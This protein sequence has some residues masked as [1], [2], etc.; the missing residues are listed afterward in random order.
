[1]CL[2]LEF[3]TLD[4]FDGEPPSLDSITVPNVV[5]EWK[6]PEYESEIWIRYRISFQEGLKGGT[7]LP[8]DIEEAL[9]NRSRV[10][11]S[12]ETER[13]V[14][15]VVSEWASRNFSMPQ[16]MQTQTG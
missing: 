9:F 5:I 14:Q 7:G 1:M 6:E 3:P 12:R 13:A 8:I 4:D 10:R 2:H 16:G 11:D 15:E